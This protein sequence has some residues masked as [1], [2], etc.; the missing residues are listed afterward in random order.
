MLRVAIVTLVLLYH[1]IAA[2]KETESQQRLLGSKDEKEKSATQNTLLFY[3]YPLEEKYWWRWPKPGTDCKK[4]GYLS[5]EHAENSAIGPPIDLDSGL[6]LT[7]H[8]SLFNSLYNR[9]KRSSRRTMDPEKASL[10]IIPYD[11]A[12]DGSVNQDNCGQFEPSS[13]IRFP[14]ITSCLT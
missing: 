3:I 4:S 1:C 14:L 9:M 2:T 8:F 10:F 12:L 5:H 7:W 13:K 11:L 6:Y